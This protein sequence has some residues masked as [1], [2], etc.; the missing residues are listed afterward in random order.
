[1]VVASSPTLCGLWFIFRMANDHY[2]R[3]RFVAGAQMKLPIRH[4]YTTNHSLLLFTS[5]KSLNTNIESSGGTKLAKRAAV[6]QKSTEPLECG[7]SDVTKRSLKCIEYLHN[8]FDLIYIKRKCTPSFQT[9]SIAVSIHTQTI[10]YG[11]L[12]NKNKTE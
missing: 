9:V 5:C 6:R 8:G 3:M 2:N 4:T 7:R 11:F 1:M 10:T 12:K